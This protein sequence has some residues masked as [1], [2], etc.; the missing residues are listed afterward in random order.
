MVDEDPTYGLEF[1]AAAF[2]RLGLPDCWVY[3]DAEGNLI[4]EDAPPIGAPS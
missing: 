2:N 4:P 1:A 3:H